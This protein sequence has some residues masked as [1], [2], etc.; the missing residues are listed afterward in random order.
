MIMIFTGSFETI[1]GQALHELLIN[2]VMADP[3]PVIGLPNQEYIE[4]LNRS[5]DTINLLNCWI[6]IGE[7]SVRIRENFRLTPDSVIILCK[8]SAVNELQNFGACLGIPSFPS[9]NNDY[10][11]IVILGPD[12]QTIHALKYA[13]SLHS[14]T[15]KSQGGWSI[16]LSDP[17]LPCNFQN[18]YKSS[19][20]PSGG[21][22]G[23]R[24]SDL[25]RL[26]DNDPPRIRGTYL[27]DSLLLLISFSESLDSISAS[28]I[29]A[30][31]LSGQQ[32]ILKAEVLPPLFD[33]VTLFLATKPPEQVF[34]ISA[35]G[36]KDCAGNNMDPNLEAKAAG[37]SVPSSGDLV[38]NEVLFNPSSGGSDY[39]EI[40]NSS[41]KS[42][43]LRKLIICGRNNAGEL[44]D[45]VP[46]SPEPRMIFPGEFVAISA[47]TR[48]IRMEYNSL[49]DFLSEVPKLPSLPDDKGIIV[50]TDE[51][52]NMI[53]ELQYDKKWH[54]PFLKNEDGISLER[55]DAGSPTNSSSNWTSCAS[56][57]K[58][59]PG[60][61]NSQSLA[62]NEIKG[63][64]RIDR[65]IFS[66]DNDGFEDF[67]FINYGFDQPGVMGSIRIYNVH[68][69]P[70]K[71]LLNNEL[72]PVSGLV[73]WNGSNE[74]NLPSPTGLYIID[75]MFHSAT[76]RKIKFR[77]AVT[78]AK[79]F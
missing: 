69:Q 42:F 35:D 6:V 4:L 70:E 47:D 17:T 78:L 19:I 76:G 40:F 52:G 46:I 49:D 21:T 71:V 72:L 23:R 38:I 34:T 8:T 45:A 63:G 36:L 48:F 11:L 43:D 10:D 64:I 12:L 30:Y 73:R 16:E 14:N 28:R 79:R 33:Q 22:P 65:K 27:K 2:E 54:H 68:G 67:L 77:E 66:P 39:V 62:N 1:S 15:L 60:K 13:N 5:T 20:D 31:K 41:Q 55:L 51:Q 32:K 25:Q 24:N 61:I 9:I 26:T 59:T 53:D 56:E 74:K 18:N 44:S 3:S 50:L 57:I 7:D 29:E 58:G 75:A 37:V